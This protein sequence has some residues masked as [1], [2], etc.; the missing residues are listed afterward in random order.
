MKGDTYKKTIHDGSVSYSVVT[1]APESGFGK[2]TKTVK[3]IIR[4]RFCSALARKFKR[5]GIRNAY[6][7]AQILVYPEVHWTKKII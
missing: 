6:A 2:H 4:R 3:Q 5:E 1:P 7:Q